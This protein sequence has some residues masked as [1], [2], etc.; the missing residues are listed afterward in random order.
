MSNLKLFLKNRSALF[1][2]VLIQIIVIAIIA[3]RVDFQSGMITDFIAR[4]AHSPFAVPMVFVVYV[5]GAFINVPQWMLH[6]AAVVTFGPL[7]GSLLAWLA[8]MVS[9]SVDF[10]IGHTL[11]PKRVE[12]LSGGVTKKLLGAIRKNGFWAS[13]AV[14]VLPTGP[15][16]FVNMA[17]GVT[18]MSFWAYLLGTGIGTIPKIVLMASLGSGAKVAL[19]GHNPVYTALAV[20]FAL[21]SFIVMWLAGKKLEARF[22]E[23]REDQREAR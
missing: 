2:V 12:K 21:V 15:F 13:M 11:G 18:K 7:K 14:R 10:W 1:W 19:G 5:V 8:T 6:G 23:K 16:V 20:L 17:A 22:R 4:F 3:W 9:A